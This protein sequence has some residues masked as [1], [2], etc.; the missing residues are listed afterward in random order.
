MTTTGG[1]AIPAATRID[2]EP[3]LD[4]AHGAPDDYG[5]CNQWW[6][7]GE[8]RW[9]EGNSTMAAHKRSLTVGIE[10]Q[11]SG[12]GPGGHGEALTRRELD[13]LSAIRSGSTNREIA[14]SLGIAVSTVKRHVEHILEK[15][16]AR[17]RAQA[18]AVLRDSRVAVVPV[19]SDQ[20]S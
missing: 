5:G 1:A 3:V 6:W 20:P 19:R 15:L 14:A 17:N 9:I 2:R 4:S 13:V 10:S 12:L 11:I 7:I 18:V 16:E 8:V